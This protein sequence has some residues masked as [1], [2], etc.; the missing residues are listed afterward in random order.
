MIWPSSAEPQPGVQRRPPGATRLRRLVAIDRERVDLGRAVVVDEDR[1]LKTSAHR[2]AS[3][4]VIA[5][6]A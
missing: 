3:A 5:A 2:S 4:R 1:G 6:P